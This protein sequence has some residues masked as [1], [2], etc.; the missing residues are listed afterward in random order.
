MTRYACH[1]TLLAFVWPDADASGSLRGMTTGTSRTALATLLLAGCFSPTDIGSSAVSTDGDST[2]DSTTSPT[3]S[4]SASTS[5]SAT[6]PTSS[7]SSA[8]SPTSDTNATEDVSG[9][10]SAEDTVGDTTTESSGSS[11]DT[12]TGQTEACVADGVVAGDEVCDDDN[13]IADDG[14]TDCT[15]DEGHACGQGSP[16]VCGP[17]CDPLLQ[18]C[19]V[20]LGC[21]PLE[22]AWICVV[23]ES[24]GNGGQ[25][26]MCEVANACGPGFACIAAEALPA[27][28]VGACCSQ[29][30]DVDE[31]GNPCP[32]GLAC[33][34]WYADEAPPDY[35]HV[36]IC[37]SA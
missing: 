17:L 4:A 3:S 34:P 19:A 1:P 11:D 5:T 28:D 35:D 26:A 8:T 36:G 7:S 16:S 31:P 27:C 9:P 13:G 2:G 22:A 30:C 33:L 18:D 15:I 32:T 25:D 21:Y 23:D 14:C 24:N 20:D 10:S 37:A 29:L 6:S 12:T